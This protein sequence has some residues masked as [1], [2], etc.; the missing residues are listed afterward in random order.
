MFQN[1]DVKEIE[2]NS[3]EKEDFVKV[4]EG[5]IFEGTIKDLTL[6]EDLL[7]HYIKHL[8]N[9][10]FKNLQVEERVKPSDEER[11]KIA[12]NEKNKMEQEEPKL[13][14]FETIL[15]LV[16]FQ[17]KK[18]FDLPQKEETIIDDLI[19]LVRNCHKMLYDPN[20][21]KKYYYEKSMQIYLFTIYI[22]LKNY[23]F[24]INKRET[25]QN[26][27]TKLIQYKK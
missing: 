12:I 5:E 9:F 26:Y 24:F 11:N 2:M 23:P 16:S 8:P 15:K 25:L 21:E 3:F 20:K 27:F 18:K 22:I 14:I 10:L 17:E 1:R 4:I 7:K 6:S 19:D 13:L